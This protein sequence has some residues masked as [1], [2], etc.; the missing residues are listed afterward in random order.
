MLHLYKKRRM[1]P[2]TKLRNRIINPD[3]YGMI[4]FEVAKTIDLIVYTSYY[5]KKIDPYWVFG[6]KVNK[7]NPIEMYFPES[8]LNEIVKVF[9]DDDWI[10]IKYSHR[11][12]KY[13]PQTEKHNNKKIADAFWSHYV[14]TDDEDGMKLDYGIVP[15]WEPQSRTRSAIFGV[16]GWFERNQKVVRALIIDEGRFTKLSDCIK[17]INALY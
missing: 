8:E 3:D 15:T 1:S 11:H 10:I 13:N 17:Q 7:R 6:F 9:T 14:P 2:I 5:S 16:Y 12:G 4:R